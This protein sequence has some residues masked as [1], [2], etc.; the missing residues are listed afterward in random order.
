LQAGGAIQMGAIGSYK[1]CGPA[2]AGIGAVWPA[3]RL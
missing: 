1:S 3:R 2:L